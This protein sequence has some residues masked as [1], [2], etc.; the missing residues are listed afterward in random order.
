MRAII[1]CLLPALLL[2]GQQVAIT[3]AMHSTR[4][5]SGDQAATHV[6]RI[7]NTFLSAAITA[8][9]VGSLDEACSKDSLCSKISESFSRFGSANVALGCRLPLPPYLSEQTQKLDLHKW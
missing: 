3:E 9:S 6:V 1:G 5:T 2:L 8:F 4:C 7:V